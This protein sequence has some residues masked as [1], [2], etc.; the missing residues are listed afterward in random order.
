MRITDVGTAQTGAAGTFGANQGSD[1]YVDDQ[2]LSAAMIK[3]GGANGQTVNVGA[4]DGA[5]DTFSTASKATSAIA[6]AAAINK[7]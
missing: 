7:I 3:I 1:G 5:D 6:K 2:A 4:S